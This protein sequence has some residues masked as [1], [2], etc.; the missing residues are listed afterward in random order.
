MGRLS[1]INQF[2]DHFRHRCICNSPDMTTLIQPRIL[3][4]LVYIVVSP[5]PFVLLVIRSL[6][7]LRI[8]LFQL[9]QYLLSCMS[10][11]M[12]VIGLTVHGLLPDSDCALRCY[13]VQF[14]VLYA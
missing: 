5:C 6:R 10:S 9:V 14:N 12:T 3:C 4:L 11:A 7:Y 13:Y 1:Y 2:E 8:L